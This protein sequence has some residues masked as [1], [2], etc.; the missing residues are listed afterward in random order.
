MP[1]T[2]LALGAIALAGL[3]AFQQQ[4]ARAHEQRRAI[5]EEVLV[6]GRSVGNEVLERLA[7][8]PFD[9][10]GPT[11]DSTALTPEAEFGLLGAADPLADAGD[12]D[13]VDGIENIA[14]TRTLTDP[15]TGAAH[16]FGF[17]I[18][19]E[20]GYVIQQDSVL[21]RTGGMRTFAKE[22]VLLV[23][24]PSLSAPLE[25]RRVYTQE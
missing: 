23:R 18:D 21:V 3:V 19:A 13:D 9:A 17:T 2:L 11:T 20:V 4:Q 22:V 24:H 12:V 10:A 15:T 1:Q 25:L 6:T 8:L 16:T 14:V 5:H 7:T